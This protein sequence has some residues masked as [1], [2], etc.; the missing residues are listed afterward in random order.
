M[1]EKG[2]TLIESVFVLFVMAIILFI[3]F[4]LEISIPIEKKE[5]QLIREIQLDLTNLQMAAKAQRKSYKMTF[6]ST[7]YIVSSPYDEEMIRY[8]YPTPYKFDKTSNLSHIRITENGTIH[9][10]G[11]LRFR[12][13]DRTLE[14]RVQIGK[15]RVNVYEK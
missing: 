9:H 3:M 4:P 10:F 7:Y 8:E 13:H 11:T 15:G 2:Y 5:A 1:N 6:Y 12:G 14:L